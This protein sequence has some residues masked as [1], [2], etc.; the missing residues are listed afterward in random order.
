VR[1]STELK[2]EQVMDEDLKR[3]IEEPPR[4][5]AGRGSGR[6]LGPGMKVEMKTKMMMMMNMKIA[7]D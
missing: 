2:E 5:P 1:Q 6:R 7:I 4:R 3:I